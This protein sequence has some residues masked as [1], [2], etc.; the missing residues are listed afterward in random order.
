MLNWT[1]QWKKK[2]E[3]IIERYRKQG[4]HSFSYPWDR[5]ALALLF[6][7]IIKL[8]FWKALLIYFNEISMY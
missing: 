8:N 4:A 1:K 3:K 7:G 5:G 2:V 6:S